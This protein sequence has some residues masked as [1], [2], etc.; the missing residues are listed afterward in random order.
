MDNGEGRLS[1]HFICERSEWI[2]ITFYNQE[3]SAERMIWFLLA[4]YR[5][6][7]REAQIKFI[8]VNFLKN[9]PH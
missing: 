7:I 4:Q 2:S 6:Y 3:L 9:D 8:P 5:P 1:A